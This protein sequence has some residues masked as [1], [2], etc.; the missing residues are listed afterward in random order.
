MKQGN[1]NH[2]SKKSKRSAL[3]PVETPL[4]RKL[5][6]EVAGLFVKA[7]SFPIARK[8]ALTR[9]VPALIG[10]DPRPLPD[11]VEE[12]RLHIDSFADVKNK[13]DQELVVN[14]MSSE[15]I[16]KNLDQSIQ[17]GRFFVSVV[18]MAVAKNLKG[19]GIKIP[20]NPSRWKA[21]FLGEKVATRVVTILASTTWLDFLTVVERSVQNRYR[22]APIWHPQIDE[23]RSTNNADRMIEIWETLPS[24]DLTN[25]ALEP[26]NIDRELIQQTAEK[27]ALKILKGRGFKILKNLS[28]NKL[29]DFFES[30]IEGEMLGRGVEY[31]L[32]AKVILESLSP[33][34]RTRLF[35]IPP[36][37]REENKSRPCGMVW[38]EMADLILRNRRFQERY[39][40]VLNDSDDSHE[41]FNF[42]SEN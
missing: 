9:C 13:K 41:P 36:K 17:S 5:G 42:F 30:V 31:P 23:V 29:K 3:P 33:T 11:Q 38:H 21:F 20:P 28:H 32:L 1:E 18:M 19:Q 22:Q 34:M 7:M 27:V 15:R 24:V 4:S 25:H 8:V 14:L 37:T 10:G 35:G 16:K 2:R 6:N 40:D 26:F 12:I 39:R